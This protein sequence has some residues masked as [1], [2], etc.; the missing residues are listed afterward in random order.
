MLKKLFLGILLL[1]SLLFADTITVFA[2]SDL[3]FALDSIKAKFLVQHP[4][5]TVNMIYGSS[6]KGRIQVEKGAPYDLYFSAN[7]DY[8]EYLHKNG[9]IVTKPRLYAIGR[10]VIWSKNKNFDAKKGFENFK[11][12]W[13]HKVTIANPSHA[14]Y[15]QKAKQALES[16]G[17]YKALEP[18]IVFGENISQTANYINMKAADIGIIALSLVLAPGIAGSEYSS[19]YL[20]DDSL[21]EPLRQGYGITKQ[22]SKS[23]LA[24]AFYEFMQTPQV[25]QIMKKYGFVVNK[26]A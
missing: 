6:G 4:D 26:Q 20:I 1:N 10:I 18:R 7:M 3:K 12:S 17:L 15:G 22:G 14:P 23:K 11:M 13:V 25:Q 2:A 21:H 9:D 8:V 16:I 24:K 5:D 19:Y